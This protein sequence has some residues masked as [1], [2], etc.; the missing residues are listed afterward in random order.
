MKH[1]LY[2]FAK[3]EDVVLWS[4][5][6]VEICLF[7]PKGHYTRSGNL[8]NFSQISVTPQGSEVL[9]AM[10]YTKKL[11]YYI[12]KSSGYLKFYFHPYTYETISTLLFCS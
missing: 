8:I 11:I 10:I 3:T 2:I 7:F 9:I 5:S 4:R 1:I 6:T 12:F